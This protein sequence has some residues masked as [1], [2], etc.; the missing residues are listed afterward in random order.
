MFRYA[1][2]DDTPHVERLVAEFYRRAG[3][4][5]HVPYCC[6]DAR[7]NIDQVIDDGF[8]LVG[9]TS[10]SGVVFYPFFANRDFKIAFCVWWTF[11]RPR[12]LCILEETIACARHQ[13]ARQIIVASHAPDHRIARVYSRLGFRAVETHH[14]L[15]L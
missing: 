1:T 13:N 2:H 12:E 8:V 14:L 4:N 11:R 10:T 6:A 9:P 3:Q 7:T 5:Y 15:D